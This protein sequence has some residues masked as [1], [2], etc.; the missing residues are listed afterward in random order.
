MSSVFHGGRIDDAITEFGGSLESWLDLST[1]INP[2]SYT[3]PEIANAAWQRLPDRLA[4][5]QLINTAK[6]YYQ[7][8]ETMDIVVGNGTQALIQNLP[9]IF[10][11][12]TVAIVSPTY[13]EHRHCWEK[14]GR[15]VVKSET[16]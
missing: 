4:Q 3:V 13:D 1:G 14:S 10:K 5:A 2:N 6:R 11:H 7:V 8:S 15:K 16:L 9:Q 12:K